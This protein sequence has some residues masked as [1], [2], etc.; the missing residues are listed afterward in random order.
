MSLPTYRQY[1][2]RCHTDWLFV[3]NQKKQWDSVS[4]LSNRPWEDLA[5]LEKTREKI[6]SSCG[7]GNAFTT[8]TEIPSYFDHS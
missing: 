4:S 3:S 1:D 5:N 7:S 6:C 8:V 2:H